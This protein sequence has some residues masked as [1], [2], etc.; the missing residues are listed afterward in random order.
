[1]NHFADM[2]GAL[3]TEAA[4]ASTTDLPDRIPLGGRTLE[5]RYT[6]AARHA[7]RQRMEPLDI[8]MELLFSCFV[9]KRI[10]F[11]SVP[12]TGVAARSPLTG[13]VSVSYRVMLTRTCG[14]DSAERSPA[15]ETVPVQKPERYV[16]RWLSVDFARGAW[17]GEFGY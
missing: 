6:A 13:P 16:P 17:R 10:A 7:L 3:L 8:E 11:R 5:L 4:F 9:A 15:R 1:M 2:R 12:D 14:T